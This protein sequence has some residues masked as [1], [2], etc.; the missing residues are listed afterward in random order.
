MYV[1]P[2]YLHVFGDFTLILVIIYYTNMG[3]YN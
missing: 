3:Q 2:F 1:Y